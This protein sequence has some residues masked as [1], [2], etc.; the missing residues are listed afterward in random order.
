MVG[1]QQT[2]S[3]HVGYCAPYSKRRAKYNVKM[4]LGLLRPLAFLMFVLA[5]DPSLIA[6]DLKQKTRDAYDRY[7]VL[8]EKKVDAEQN[9]PNFFWGDVAPRDEELKQGGIVI[10]KA[11]LASSKDA[12]V[13]DGLVHHWSGFVF[14][15]D[16]NLDKVLSFLEDYDHHQDYYK[17]EVARSK[18]LHRD[19]DHFVAYL[20]FAKKKI[21]TVVLNTEHD[22]H[23]Y[24]LDS[25]R[26]YSRSHTTRVTEVENA[27]QPD[28]REKPP[29]KG[30]GYMWSMDTYWRFLERDGGVYVRCDAISLTRDVPTGLGWLIG[31]FITSIPRESLSATLK[32][33]R[34][35][36]GR[37]TAQQR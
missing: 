30:E 27:N 10:E 1:C 23:Y 7:L 24:K 3:S 12:K 16:T 36:I 25:T 5:L 13:P 11:S 19:D 32:A 2:P 29:G 17:P 20:R 9:S 18:L 6:F 33:T 31:P 8:A 26:A 28:E 37:H 34:G 21:I 14:I 4:Q 15:P 22:A 35:G